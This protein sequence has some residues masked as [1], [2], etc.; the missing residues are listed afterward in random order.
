MTKGVGAL[1]FLWVGAVVAQG[2][3]YSVTSAYGL[4]ETVAR[5]EEALRVEGVIAH[6]QMLDDAGEAVAGAVFQFAY[7]YAA[8][9]TGQCRWDDH[10]A[11]PFSTKIWADAF[12]KVNIS[13]SAPPERVNEFGVIECG[14]VVARIHKTLNKI[15][16]FA[17][18]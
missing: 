7:P 10:N 8:T 14:S 2:Q 12:G 6:A 3:I 9:Y 11:E 4:S 17:A 13:Y 1:F 5:F 18:Q 15:V 16:K